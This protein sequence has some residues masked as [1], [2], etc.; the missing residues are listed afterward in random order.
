[1]SRLH[2]LWAYYTLLIV[3]S[4]K[5][6][7]TCSLHIIICVNH[8]ASSWQLHVT[9]ELWYSRVRKLQSKLRWPNSNTCEIFLS[10]LHYTILRIFCEFSIHCVFF[11]WLC[12][13]RILFLFCFVLNGY[14]FASSKRTCNVL[15]IN[16]QTIE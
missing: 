12:T 3:Q 13:F 1:M 2:R 15:I 14:L 16:I 10:A 9:F 5:Q 6:I 7:T 8:D 4:L 11:L